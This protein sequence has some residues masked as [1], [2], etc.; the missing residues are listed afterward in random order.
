MKDQKGDKKHAEYD[1]FRSVFNSTGY[2]F[3]E[4][5]LDTCKT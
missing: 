2:K 5:Y 1:V 3:K 4:P